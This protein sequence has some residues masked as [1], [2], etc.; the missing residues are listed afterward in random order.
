MYNFLRQ[1]SATSKTV[2]R[3]HKLWPLIINFVALI[4]HKPL[5]NLTFVVCPMENEF[6][7]ARCISFRRFPVKRNAELDIVAR[8][9]AIKT[10]SR[11]RSKFQPRNRR[12]AIPQIRK[13]PFFGWKANGRRKRGN[14]RIES[15]GVASA[16]GRGFARAIRRK[17][18][19]STGPRIGIQKSWTRLRVASS[20]LSDSFPA[21][22]KLLIREKVANLEKGVSIC[23]AR[24]VQSEFPACS[25]VRYLDATRNNV[26]VD[27]H[28]EVASRS[29]YVCW[30]SSAWK[31]N[32]TKFLRS[33]RTTGI[34]NLHL[35]GQKRRK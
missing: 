13:P 28:A 20:P 10:R 11:N 34:R 23:N 15:F 17:F 2:K 33:Q 35:L 5:G 7:W 32:I 22:V 19:K 4:R 8:R 12:A 14:A 3:P 9:A 25:W 27:L 18:T 30:E 24:R 29:F 16:S 31:L 26:D 1:Y 6:T 21:I